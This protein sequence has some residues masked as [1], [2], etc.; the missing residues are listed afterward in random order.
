[1]DIKIDMTPESETLL[2]D[3]SFLVALFFDKDSLHAQAKKES[4]LLETLRVLPDFIISETATVLRNK[5][6]NEESINFVNIFTDAQNVEVKSFSLEFQSF[7]QEF[8]LSENKNLSFI[9]ASLLAL[10]K[11]GKYRVVTFDKNL[12]KLI[13]KFDKAKKFKK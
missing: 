5:V 8:T 7:C 10:H 12:K 6:T 2:F 3:T 4:Y 9:D 11:T 1:M 13:D